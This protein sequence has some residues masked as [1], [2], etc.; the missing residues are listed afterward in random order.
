MNSEEKFTFEEGPSVFALS[1]HI[2]GGSYLIVLNTCA[3]LTP[4]LVGPSLFESIIIVIV[5]SSEK[6]YAVLISHLP[7]TLHT[8]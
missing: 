5:A 7:A 8:K 1:P 3:A 2:I 6:N 4:P